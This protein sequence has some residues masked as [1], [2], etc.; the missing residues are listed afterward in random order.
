MVGSVASL[1][2]GAPAALVTF[3]SYFVA[4]LLL[5]CLMRPAVTLEVVW[6]LVY[7]HGLVPFPDTVPAGMQASGW[8]VQHLGNRYIYLMYC[9]RE[10][11]DGT[12]QYICCQVAGMRRTLT[13][14][15]V[16]EQV[17]SIGYD[18]SPAYN[19]EADEP[20]TGDDRELAHKLY[21]IV[22]RTLNKTYL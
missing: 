21:Q 7:K 4:P 15:F 12:K 5:F 18:E 2:T 3:F 13:L 16:N 17:R 11:E 9:W 20:L 6:H 22:Q 8:Y 19:N 10:E 1:L 14:F